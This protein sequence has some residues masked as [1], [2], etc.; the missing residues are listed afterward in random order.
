MK[1]SGAK[2]VAKA[3]HGPFELYLVGLG[4]VGVRHS[5]REAED[6][7][8]ASKRVFYVDHGFGIREF[9]EELCPN[10][11]PLLGEY[12][13]SGSRLTTY[14]KMAALAVNA[15]LDDPP[16]CFATYGHPTMFVY[17]SM[18]IQR[19]AGLLGLRVH[20]VPGISIFDT[21]LIDLGLDPGLTGFQMYEATAL[22]IEERILQPDVPCLLLQVDTVESAL[23]TRR[24]SRPNRFVRLQQHLEK[25]YPPD[26][27]VISVLSSTFPI[28]VPIRQKFPLRRLAHEYAKGTHSG[29]L[30]IPPL[31]RAGSRNAELEKQLYDPQHLRRM[32]R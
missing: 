18:L 23:F 21:V 5:T 6:C 7:I 27:E 28:L 17:P 12:K 4:I 3:D 22:L 25:F 8:K 32:T 19:A 31:G 1:S 11:T 26:H 13:E 16:V 24:Q 10:V 29:T 9:L 2:A 20:V 15:A 30:Y 14:Q